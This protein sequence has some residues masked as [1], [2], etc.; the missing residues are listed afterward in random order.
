M[1]TTGV[2]SYQTDLQ[3][4]EFWEQ[5]LLGGMQVEDDYD[6]DSDPNVPTREE[7][8]FQNGALGFW[9][10]GCQVC[11]VVMGPCGYDINGDALVHYIEKPSDTL[12]ERVSY[13][14]WDLRP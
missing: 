3:E 8:I 11:G 2:P 14:V 6:P 13:G 7:M 5:V 9:V 10:E 12:G 1:D 4:A